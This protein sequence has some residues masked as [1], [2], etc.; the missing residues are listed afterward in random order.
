MQEYQKLNK[1]AKKSWIISRLLGALITSIILISF[2]LFLSKVIDNF[3][4]INIFVTVGIIIFITIL[5]INSII[6]PIFE[7]KQWR[8]TITNDKIEF[9]E[10]IYFKRTVLIPIIRIQHIQLNQGPIN[11]FFKLCNITIFTAGGQ[12]KI[13][14]IEMEKAEEISEYLKE[15]IKIKFHQELDNCQESIILDKELEN[16][17]ETK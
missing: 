13:P 3:D 8:Y 16:Y 2:K 12:H 4:E 5:L 17:D 15:L 7:Y 1:N 11:K 6:Y 14:N 10:G 9:T